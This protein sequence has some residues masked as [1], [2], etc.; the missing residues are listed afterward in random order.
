MD[1]YPDFFTVDAVAADGRVTIRVQGELDFATAPQLRSAL[2]GVDGQAV[3]LDLSAVTFCDGAGV[4]V[5]EEARQRLGAR[6]HIGPPG[7]AVLKVARVL[8]VAWLVADAT[9]PDRRYRDAR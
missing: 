3:D 9:G 5:L 4:R 2:G 1:G 6:L 8:D 7:V